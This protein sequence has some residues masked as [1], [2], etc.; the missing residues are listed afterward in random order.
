MIE[1]IIESVDNSPK[2]KN[3]SLGIL[4]GMVPVIGI[5]LL[6]MDNIGKPNSLIKRI[7][8]VAVIE[9]SV[10][11]GGLSQYTLTT[12]NKDELVDL[13]YFNTIEKALV[14]P[15]VSQ[16]LEYISKLF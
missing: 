9:A 4:V 5:P 14:N 6:T 3:I 11:L 12:F 13:S 10:L 15:Y 8:P 7:L 2:T 1:K 16:G